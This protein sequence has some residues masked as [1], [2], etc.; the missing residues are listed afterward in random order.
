[1][2]LL[3]LIEGALNGAFKGT[4]KD[5]FERHSSLANLRGESGAHEA[6]DVALLIKSIQRRIGESLGAFPTAAPLEIE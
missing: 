2:V 3:V 4:F 6:P 1:M 5:K